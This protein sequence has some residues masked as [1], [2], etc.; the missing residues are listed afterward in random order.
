MI[1]DATLKY[2]GIIPEC[3]ERAD[4]ICERVCDEHGIDSDSAVWE[5]VKQDFEEQ[6]HDGNLT[7]LIIYFI[8]KNLRA[9]LDESG[10]V[11]MSRTDWYIDGMCSS[12]MIDGEEA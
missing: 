12:F 8:F 9:A 2:L 7:N 3:I 4:E 1:E 10:V 6:V 11:D 5:Y